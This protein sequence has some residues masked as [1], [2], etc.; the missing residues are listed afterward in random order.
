M[1]IWIKFLIDTG[2]A[3]SIIDVSKLPK[4]T[5]L[6]PLKTPIALSTATG[7]P[8]E[9]LGVADLTMKMDS[10]TIT[11][12]FYVVRGLNAGAILGWDFQSLR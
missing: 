9:I 12:R 4:G 2:A 6:L 11:W 3:K 1:V 10:K 8:I 5:Q 7:T